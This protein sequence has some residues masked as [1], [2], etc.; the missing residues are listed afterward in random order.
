[1]I[2]F[3]NNFPKNWTFLNNNWTFSKIWLQELN[4]LFFENSKSWSLFTNMSHSKNST[5]LNIFLVSQ[6]IGPFLNMTQRIELFFRLT[7]LNLLFSVTQRIVSF[8]IKITWRIEP[9]F[10]GYVSM[11]WTTFFVD[12]SKIWTLFFPYDSKTWAFFQKYDLQELN[13]LKNMTQR[14]ELFKYGSKNWTFPFFLKT[15][16]IK[17]WFF[18]IWL[19]AFNPPFFNLTQRIEPSFYKWLEDL[20]FLLQKCLKELNL[21]WKNDSKNWFSE[22]YQSDYLNFLMTQ[23]IELFWNMTFRT[24]PFFQYDSWKVNPSFQHTHRNWT[25]LFNMTLTNIWLKELNLFFEYES[26]NWTLF[27][28]RIELFFFRLTQRFC[29]IELK[30]S[31]FFFKK[32]DPKNRTFYFL[33]ICYENCFSEDSQN[34]TCFSAL[35][36]EWN[37]WEYD[38][39]NWTSLEI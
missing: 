1:M 3:W 17:D 9:S 37:I 21:S 39:K 15:H 18:S 25:F 10:F 20:N 4:F 12:D 36:Q 30:E 6:R 35:P 26:K 27:M 8:F 13:L 33:K 11:N 34:W 31:N 14:I 32:N 7:E 2:F 23:R 5:V 24:E 22:K 28:T 16:R 19:K 29:W 38:S